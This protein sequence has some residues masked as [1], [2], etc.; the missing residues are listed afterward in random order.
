MK[1]DMKYIFKYCSLAILALGAT[2]TSCSD[3]Y[4]SA[5]GSNYVAELTELKIV[6]AGLSGDSIV[7]GKVDQTTK[8]ITFPR[9]SPKTKNLAAIQVEGTFADGSRLETNVYDFSM[10][11]TNPKKEILITVLNERKY[12]VYNMQLRLDVPIWG[13]DFAKPA[14]IYD[15]SGKTPYP[16]TGG[17]LRGTAFDGKY[18]LIVD[19]G[20]NPHV[21]KVSDVE[22]GKIDL[23]SLNMTGV[24]GGTFAVNMGALAGG[25]IYVANLSGGAASPLKVYCWDDPTKAPKVILNANKATIPDVGNRHGD[26]F[27]MDLDNN[28][29]GFMFFGDNSSTTV[30]RFTVSNFTEVSSPSTFQVAVKNN[31]FMSITRIGNTGQYLLGG[32]NLNLSLVSEG[33]SV[34]KELPTGTV[35][36]EAMEPRVFEFNKKRYLMTTAAAFGG[37]STINPGLFVYDI[38]AGNDMVQALDAFENSDDK[39]PVLNFSLGGSGNGNPAAQTGYYVTKDADGNDEF[40][41]LFSARTGSG[42]ALLKYPIAKQE[43]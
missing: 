18:I 35:T 8:L 36:R 7:D 12:M 33:G 39:N 31:G 37:A 22:E 4:P 38:T 30:L 40:I 43:D 23:I 34:M 15:Y 3:S 2:M 1:T 29:N 5:P 25:K 9:L 27:S 26:N 24:T 13:A 32:V 20:T 14:G 41:Y 21:L 16:N 42:W 11:E 19:R 17:S 10:T 28:G 6:N